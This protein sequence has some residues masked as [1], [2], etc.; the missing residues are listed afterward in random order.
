MKYVDEYRDG[1]AR[2][3]DRR[4][5]RARG[6][7][8]ARLPLH[9]VLR[10]PYPRDLAL[11]PR[12]P[13]ARERAHDP[14]AGL[15]GL[16]AADRRAS[17]WRSPAR[18]G[19]SVTLCAY[20]DLMRVPGSG[21]I[22]PDEGQ[23]RR[24]RHPHG[25]FDA[26]RDCASPRRRRSARSCSSPSAS[27][28]RRR[29]PRSRSAPRA[30]KG[31]TNFS[32]LCN[33]VLTPAAMQR[34]PA[35]APTCASSAAS[36]STASSARRMS[37]PSSA[38]SPIGSSPSEFGKPVVDRRLRAARRRAGDPDAGAPDQRGPRRGREPIYPRRDSERQPQGAGRSRRGVRDC[39]RR[40]NGAASATCPMSALQLRAGLRALRRRA[41]LRPRREAGARQSGLRM[42]RDP[43]RRQEAAR[44][45]AVRHRLH[46]RHADGLVHGVARRR[47]RGALDLRPLPRGGQSRR[48][49]RGGGRVSAQQPIRR[50][51]DLKNGRVDL[52]HGAGG[53]AMAQLI[54]DIFHAAFDNDWL[55]AGNDQSAFD[56][57]AGRMVMTTD[58]YVVSPLFFPGGDIG[59]L[60]VH[61][62][63]NDIAMAG[64]RP[65][66]LSASFII[67][68]GLPLA[69]LKRIATSMGEAVARGRRADHHRRHQGRRARQGGQ[70]CSSRPPGVG[71]A[72]PGIVL[73]SDAARPG[74]V[75]IVSGTI[76][77]PRRRGH[78][79]AREPRIRDGNSV[80]HR[81]ASRSGRRDG[82]RGR[83]RAARHARSD[84]RR[85]RGDA[86]RTRAPVRRRLRDRGGRDPGARRGR[87]RLRVARARPAQRRQRGQA[88]R[89][90]RARIR[91]RGSLAAMRAHP[92]G[93]ASRGHRPGG[94]GPQ[95]FRARCATA[96][97]G[98]RIVDWLAGEQLP[99]IC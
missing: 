85:P 71:V 15:P 46:A 93:R 49:R 1:S 42:R 90:R 14:R 48:R 44:L 33:H 88:R 34:H 31:L 47:L 2:A 13:A 36:R 30:K 3:D 39:A 62:T 40:S 73:S 22:E 43:A 77:R 38:R 20:G 32:I 58:A 82:R 87:R 12:G 59:S 50:K 16:R 91:R 27:R 52:S 41:A 76:G 80:G 18:G 11:R 92:L 63:I 65:L 37:A 23:G 10:R 51:L 57:A 17:T 26:R 68:E 24:R 45:Q 19:P 86:Q 55:R 95:S 25:L 9:G 89:D 83:R 99:R 7:A 5:D 96:F 53:R 66:Y 6:R 74:D 70:A 75:V 84:A 4:G 8:G 60:A 78:V 64:A 94:R 28:R 98:G 81:G 79:E 67:E 35:R 56:V 54:E 61:G 29:R 72:P 21:G 97:G 69:D